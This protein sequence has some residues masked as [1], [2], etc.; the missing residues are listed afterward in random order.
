[1]YMLF[2]HCNYEYYLQYF[3][4]IYNIFIVYGVDTDLRFFIYLKLLKQDLHM[5]DN[6]EKA[7]AF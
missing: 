3:C 4:S 2:K 1:M 6:K 5:R 7:D